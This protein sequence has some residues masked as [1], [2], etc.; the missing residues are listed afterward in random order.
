MATRPPLHLVGKGEPV[1]ADDEAVKHAEEVA[2]KIVEAAR[3]GYG[4]W[5]YIDGEDQIAT[6]AGD[7]LEMSATAE[8]V[9]RDLKRQALGFVE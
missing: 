7:L 3:A 5:V 9:A 8:E 1:A 2:A 4:F 6:Y